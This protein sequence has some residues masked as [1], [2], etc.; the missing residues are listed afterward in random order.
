MKRQLFVLALMG[1]SPSLTWAQQKDTLLVEELEEISISAVRASEDAP[2]AKI[3]AD[4]KTIQS[5]FSG[6][7]GAFLLERLSPSLVTYSESGTGFSNYGFM[8]LRGMDQT[9]INITLNG[10]PL[11]DMIDQG[12]F[13]SNFT[14]FGNSV[15][16]VQV[17]RG[18]GTSSNG[19]SSYAGSVNFE[20]I[21]LS[22]AEPS[23]ELQFT[24]GS[25]NT[26]R[27]SAEVQ[28]GLMENKTAFYAR[29]SRLQSDGYR[30]HSGTESNSLFLSGGYF[31]KK[32]SLKF[33]AF[34]GQSQ[35]DLSYTPVP[36]ALIQQDPRTNLVSENDIDDFGQYLMQLQHTWRVN[37]KSAWS[38]T[39]YYGGAGGDFPFGY[40]DSTSPGNV[41][42]INY[43]LENRH[44]G[45][46]SNYSTDLR[47]KARNFGKLDLGLHL[48]TF[49]RVNIEHFIPALSNPYYQ[50]S[51]RKEEVAFFA[52]W[53]RSFS[54]LKVF[55]DV[56]VRH[57]DL[58]LS[59][60]RNFLGE[61]PAIP[62][63]N[64]LFVNPKLGLTYDLPA[65]WQFY[66]SFGRSG[67]EPT[68]TDIVG[69][70]QLNTG[71]L[72][73][74]RDIN[75]VDAEFV[76][77]FEAGFR[78]QTEELRVDFNGYYMLFEN[79]IAPIGPFINE[80]FYQV[81]MNH[82]SSFR[83]GFEL[84]AKYQLSPS[85]SVQSQV[86]YLDAQISSYSP[87]GIDVV[88]NDVR[89][90]LS[91]E[92]NGNLAVNYSHKQFQMQVRGRFLSKQSIEL[93][94]EDP[95]MFVPASFILDATASWN[96]YREH[97]LS[98][99]INNLT[100]ELY[101]TFGAPE[102]LDFDGVS[103]P[104]FLVQAPLNLYATLSL[105]F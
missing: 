11:N 66:A 30:R 13:F 39:I 89:S 7:D 81:F 15:Q 18:V 67:R 102:D 21:S 78:W 33:T 86:A 72:A 6:Q 69:A 24:G 101:Y 95:Q 22:Q 42:A 83:R 64:Y 51:S 17:Q 5:N 91:P 52:K 44:F 19:V 98:L 92:W 1:L 99:Q 16:S 50:D 34:A 70:I 27:A 14:D 3:T 73:Q 48:Y 58:I 57:V 88:Y 41:A 75:S 100:N 93:G 71:N 61:D 80:G 2:V 103:G 55:A 32:H 74:V 94:N 23:A 10:V 97:S 35:N 43:P 56:Q 105:R 54:R 45:W 84:M 53:N 79:E 37:E 26:L 38:N 60:D 25:F 12:V 40:P 90:V 47:K 49:D 68:R 29:V 28:T 59:G 20:S 36:L 65:N 46:L 9:R 4:L 8:R 77:D 31:G 82:E 85:F 96:F 104:A 76:N 87:A 62:T 63:R